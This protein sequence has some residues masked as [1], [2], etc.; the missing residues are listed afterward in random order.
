MAVLNSIRKRGFFL[1]LII[2]LAL[3]AFILSD[4]IN[5]GKSSSN[6]QNVVAT[7]NG[8]E[9]SREEFM[10]Q[11]DDYQ[12]TLGPNAS[13]SQAMNL[14]WDRELKSIL[15]GQQSEDL[16]MSIGEEELN[17]QL[18]LTLSNNPTFQDENGIYSEA[19]LVEY[20]ASI[21]NNAAARQQWQSF[22]DGIKESLLQKNYGN[23]VRSGLVTTLADGEQQY[24]F[25]NDKINVEFIQVPYT[26]IADEDIPVTDAEIEAYIR[27]HSDRFQVEPMVDIEYVSFDE[28]PSIEDVQNAETEMAS[29]V[30]GFQSAEDYEFFVNDNSD[31]NYVNRW[32]AGKD[33][34]T[35][36]KDTILNL[37]H[38]TVYG[39]YKY[40]DTYNL[41]KVVAT[42]QMPDSVEARHILIP[43]GLSS[44]DSITRSP[45]QAKSFADSLLTVLKTNKSKFA[46]FVNKYSVDSGS[47]EKGGHYDWFGYNT[48][49]APFRDFCFEGKVGDMDVVETQFGYH[50]IEIEGQKD[51]KEMVKIATVTKE[52]ESSES[53]LSEVFSESAKFEEAAR[54]GDFTKAAEDKGLTPKPVNRIGILDA[55]IPGIGNNRT[56]IN[57]A[58]EDESAVG[59]VKRFNVNNSY[60]I[61]RLTRKSKEKALMSI[62]EASATVT[63]ILR[64]QKK[65][66]KIKES[67]KGTT[68]QEMATSQN[69]AVKTASAIT[70]S[71]PTLAGAGTE[72]F[73]V[74]SAFGK[75]PGEMTGIL[76]GVSGV[77]V[78]RVL[79]VNNAPA[80]ENYASYANQLKSQ[81][82]ASSV[83][84]SVFNAL[85]KSA[86]IED[87]RADFY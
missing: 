37:P 70:R 78:V 59:D 30:A 71:N 76:E 67:I 66:Q 68:L 55:S 72:P 27:S 25:E 35:P 28:K 45:A 85:K 64:N 26:K 75:K 73:V 38:G 69:V 77:F 48:M 34:P 2:A 42:M 14:I 54:N 74:G 39:P 46:D 15:Y 50:L 4:I 17:E 41:S 79:S 49:V 82:N 24:K 20:V 80:L 52:I 65:A 53:T 56:I 40:N 13:A 10:T 43:I 86:D 62:S 47:K 31:N 12:R 63:P 87:N 36:I 51:R 29:L 21:Q 6:V 1:I 44:A 81:I 7:V 22:I 3:F 18:N 57:W 32:F 19:R 11:V 83:S 33:L 16:G 5:K 8:T 61:V 60:V 58:F 84:T 23:L 9:I